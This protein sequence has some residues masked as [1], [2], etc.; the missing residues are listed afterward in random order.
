[1]KK[2]N[3]HKDMI[4]KGFSFPV[5]INNAPFHKLGNTEILDIDPASIKG[6]VFLEIINKPACLTG[7]EVKFIRTTME[8]TQEAFAKKIGIKDRSLISKWEAQ[9]GKSTG[10]DQHTELLIRLKALFF[11]NRKIK[12][13]E[14]DIENLQQ[15][16]SSGVKAFAISID[17]DDAK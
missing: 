7:A 5:M 12:L 10:M 3:Y 1:M 15:L 16:T 11:H 8:Q 14:A 9:K 17:Y 4:F 6:Q 13:S 2:G